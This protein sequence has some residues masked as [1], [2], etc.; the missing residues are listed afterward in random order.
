MISFSG[1]W[2]CVVPGRSELFWPIRIALGGVS[3]RLSCL[4]ANHNRRWSY[5]VTEGDADVVAT[6]STL[7]IHTM[8]MSDKF[9]VESLNKSD[10]LL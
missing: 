9:V 6:Q 10:D 7:E 8:N 3:V 4:S 2:Q 5:D 1:G